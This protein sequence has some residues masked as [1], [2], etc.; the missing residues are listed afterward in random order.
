MLDFVGGNGLEPNF[1]L[2]EH[3]QE[4]RESRLECRPATCPEPLSALPACG[5][6]DAKGPFPRIAVL[7]I[8]RRA[9]NRS[10][11]LAEA[12]AVG[13]A[14]ECQDA[15]CRREHRSRGAGDADALG[16]ASGPGPVLQCIGLACEVGAKNIDK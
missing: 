8:N 6:I 9:P 5:Q 2:L 7:N 16:I 3:L 4:L 11:L 13:S 1:K 12:G 10:N 15:D 14:V